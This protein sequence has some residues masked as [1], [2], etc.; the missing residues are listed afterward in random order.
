MRAL[1]LVQKYYPE[2]TKVIDGKK[3]IRVEVTKKDSNSAAVRDHKACA[4][5]VA[6]KRKLNLDGVLISVSTAYLV[7]GKKA[8]R[9]QLPPSVSREVVSFDRHGGVW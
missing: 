2:V 5:A 8:T 9:F 7:K 3:P 4:M 1:R 6:C